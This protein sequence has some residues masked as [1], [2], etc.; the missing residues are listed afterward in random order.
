M[1]IIIFSYIPLFIIA[2][3]LVF[4]TIAFL[5]FT[6]DKN[7]RKLSSMKYLAVI[8]ILDTISLF[9]WNLNQFL[10]PNFNIE[11]EQINVVTCR[12]ALYVQFCSIQISSLLRC[13]ICVDRYFHI[14]SISNKYCLPFGTPRSAKIWTICTAIFIGIL[15]FHLLILA[16]SYVPKDPEEA[17]TYKFNC[18]RTKYF[19]LKPNWNYS[20]FILN[21]TFPFAI[22]IIFNSLLIYKTV[23]IRQKVRLQ[24]KFKQMADLNRRRLTLSLIF[25][26]FTYLIF[27]LPP[28]IF[29]SFFP[30]LMYGEN[31]QAL[32]IYFNSQVF[33][34]HSLLF[35]ECYITNLKFRQVFNWYL[36]KILRKK[37]K[38]PKDQ[39]EVYRSTV[40]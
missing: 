14:T 2:N 23:K 38:V 5:I 11:I 10:K 6:Y 35:F 32:A 26:S 13:L 34:L 33:S 31:G 25:I 16:G 39:F 24:S 4:N 19:H 36:K 1:S 29:F 8:S 30:T 21:C 20:N 22:M 17:R 12:V 9:E 18:Y 15:N 40:L 37:I 28:S 7:L 27:H 3:A